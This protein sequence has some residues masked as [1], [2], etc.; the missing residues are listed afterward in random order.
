MLFHDTKV[1]SA[2]VKYQSVTF[3]PK[4]YKYQLIFRKRL[5]NLSLMSQSISFSFSS[6]DK[7]PPCLRLQ[8]LANE[9]FCKTNSM[10]SSWPPWCEEYTFEDIEFRWLTHH[11]L[12]NLWKSDILRNPEMIPSFL[13]SLSSLIAELGSFCS[14]ERRGLDASTAKE[15]SSSNHSPCYHQFYLILL[16]PMLFFFSSWGNDFSLWG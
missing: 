8:L 6:E 16:L 10:T 1:N 4:C 9:H 2:T 3:S 15:H 5:R 12:E 14:K 11:Y 7:T 13:W